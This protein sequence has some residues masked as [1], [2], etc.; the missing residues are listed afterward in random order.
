LSHI[1]ETT[2]V[3]GSLYS[4]VVPKSYGTASYYD[5]FW[6]NANKTKRYFLK[7]EKKNPSFIYFRL[8]I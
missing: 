1:F 6:N 4:T 5:R 7:F 3:D 2:F 8:F